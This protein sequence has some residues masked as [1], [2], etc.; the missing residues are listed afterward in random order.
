MPVKGKVSLENFGKG[1]HGIVRSNEFQALSRADTRARAAA[2]A[3]LPVD[4]SGEV[5]VYGTLRASI[6]TPPTADTFPGGEG[7]LSFG[8][9]G[10]RAVAEDTPKGTSLEES[11]AADA[12]AV[13]KA[14]P[15]DIND[16]GEFT[17][18]RACGRGP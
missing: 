10:L 5:E 14:T 15:L 18:H 4:S 12:G 8:I 17:Q 9:L 11:H 13:L 2:D 7:D 1:L 6:R 16:K 3:L